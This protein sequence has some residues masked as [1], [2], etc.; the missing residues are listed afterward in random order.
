MLVY[1]ASDTKEANRY[2]IRKCDNLCLPITRRYPA[3]TTPWLQQLCKII[4]ARFLSITREG[5]QTLLYGTGQRIRHRVLGRPR[6]YCVAQILKMPNRPSE[7]ADRLPERVAYWVG[8]AD[9]VLGNV[10][11]IEPAAKSQ[12]ERPPQKQSGE[13]KAS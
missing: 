7:T 5:L 13:K 3:G 1:C 8:L 4:F 2:P 10:V 6:W 12:K 9:R 11:D